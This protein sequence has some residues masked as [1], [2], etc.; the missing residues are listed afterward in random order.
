M[1]QIIR[2]EDGKGIILLFLLEELGKHPVHSK[3]LAYFFFIFP[4]IN[5]GSPVPAQ[6]TGLVRAIISYYINIVQL[7]RIMQ[8]LQIVDE[9]AYDTFL[10]VGADHDSKGMARLIILFFFSSRQAENSQY[11]VVQR[12][13]Y[14]DHLN[15]YHDDIQKMFHSI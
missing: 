11:K 5:D 2:V 1:N 9:L 4:R 15:G 10:I 14:D 3:A 6:L 13:H 12:K 8:Y 7:F